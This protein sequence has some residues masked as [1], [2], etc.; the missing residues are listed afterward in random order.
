MELV[1]EVAAEEEVT[2]NGRL[3][4]AARRTVRFRRIISELLD[5]GGALTDDDEFSIVKFLVEA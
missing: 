3:S 1:F 5:E 4:S 2:D